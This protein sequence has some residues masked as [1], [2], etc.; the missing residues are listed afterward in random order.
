MVK[1]IRVASQQELARIF[2]WKI[3]LDLRVKAGK[4]PAKGRPG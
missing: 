2:G 4:A 1:A 3:S